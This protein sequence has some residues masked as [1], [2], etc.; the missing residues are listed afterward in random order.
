MP[1]IMDMIKIRA[2]V[3]RKDKKEITEAQGKEIYE[4]FIAVLDKH[5]LGD[6]FQFTEVNSEEEKVT[7]THRELLHKLAEGGDDWVVDML[8]K[9]ANAV[10]SIDKQGGCYSGVY[11]TNG[12][13]VYFK[14]YDKPDS[15]DKLQKSLQNTVMVKAKQQGIIPQ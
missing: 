7:N 6:G 15:I 4:D 12:K 8:L 10:L 5:G 1:R 13:P 3:M 11:D 14:F 9:L 2:H